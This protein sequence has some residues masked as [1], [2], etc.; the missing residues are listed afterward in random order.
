M[1]RHPYYAHC[2]GVCQAQTLHNVARHHSGEE[3]L[4][5]SQCKSQR[6]FPPR[7]K[8]QRA[9]FDAVLPLPFKKNPESRIAVGKLRKGD[10]VRFSDGHTRTLRKVRHGSRHSRF[11]D[12]YFSEGGGTTLNKSTILTIVNDDVIHENPSAVES[13]R[14]LL[15]DFTGRDPQKKITR[16]LPKPPRAGLVFGTLVQVG[17]RSRRDGALYRHTFRSN[18]SRPLLVASHD[19]RSLHI[20]GG[21]YRFTDR[22]IEDV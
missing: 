21:R 14:K 2:I 13:A 7:K 1:A 11:T 20:V 6:P 12:L 22:G 4:E 9:N 17:Y 5:C 16:A 3:L 18:K 10:V 15:R 8:M 19:G